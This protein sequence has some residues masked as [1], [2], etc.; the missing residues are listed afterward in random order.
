MCF[1]QRGS[2]TSFALLGAFHYFSNTLSNLTEFQLQ[3]NAQTLCD[4]YFQT[5]ETMDLWIPILSDRLESLQYEFVS[6]FIGGEC[7][8]QVCF[9]KISE[10][11]L[12]Y[13]RKI[14][15][16]KSTHQGS[17]DGSFTFIIIQ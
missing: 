5:L 17:Q 12:F 11:R 8:V 6:K 15:L 2:L 14:F 1:A 3:E 10:K 7:I 16:M 4:L 9:F 13:F